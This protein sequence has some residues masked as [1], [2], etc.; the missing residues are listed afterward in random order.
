LR[1]DWGEVKFGVMEKALHAKFTQHEDLRHK[2]V[3]TGSATLI[4]NSPTDRIWGCGSERDGQNH[5]GRILMSI[6]A[7]FN[8]LS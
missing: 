7:V 1:S 3:C 2:L 8:P 4:E 6:R 5:L